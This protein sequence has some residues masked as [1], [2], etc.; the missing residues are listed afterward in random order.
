[1]LWPPV[2]HQRFADHVLTGLDTCIAQ[3]CQLYRISLPAENSVHN[4]GSDRYQ[5]LQPAVLLAQ[6]SQL[7]QLGYAES[8]VLLLPGV[9]N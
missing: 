7:P 1:M 6:L 2:A 5:A 9:K 8:S 4:P 3:F